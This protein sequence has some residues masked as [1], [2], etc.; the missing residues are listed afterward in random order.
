MKNDNKKKIVVKG[1]NKE[2]PALFPCRPMFG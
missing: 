1:S 2:K